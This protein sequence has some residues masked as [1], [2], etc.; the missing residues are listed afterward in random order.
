MKKE[1][2]PVE[3]LAF[4][5]VTQR[6]VAITLANEGIHCEQLSF[7]ID[8]SLGESS[9]LFSVCTHFVLVQA[10]QRTVCIYQNDR[11]CFYRRLL[12]RAFTNS[13]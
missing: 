1:Q 9:E 12:L 4:H 13:A 7:A 6:S 11:T 2:D 10:T 8:K 5:L 3:R